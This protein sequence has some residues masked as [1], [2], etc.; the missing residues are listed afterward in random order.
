[1]KASDPEALRSGSS[2]RKSDAECCSGMRVYT[3]LGKIMHAGQG[4]Y[5]TGGQVDSIGKLI[6]QKRE[7]RAK[8]V[9]RSAP[10]STIKS[11]T[12]TID[13]VISLCVAFACLVFFVLF[14]S[15]IIP[16]L[17]VGFFLS[18]LFIILCVPIPCSCCAGIG[19]CFF[20]ILLVTI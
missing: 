13:V 20:G 6:T 1:M 5:T 3:N 8:P 9:L 16:V 11:P 2:I 7:R 17:G 10:A 19:I 18:G 14:C 4:F 12:N 15:V